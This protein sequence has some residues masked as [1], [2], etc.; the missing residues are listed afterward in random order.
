MPD[1]GPAVGTVVNR[2]LAVKPGEDVLV[3]ADAGTRTIGEALREA[4]ARPG[5]TPCSR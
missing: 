1:L 4:A 3:L 2:C 5:P